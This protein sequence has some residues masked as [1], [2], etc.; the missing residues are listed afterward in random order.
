MY[1]VASNVTSQN[2][3]VQMIQQNKYSQ[4]YFELSSAIV[5]ECGQCLL[6]LYMYLLLGCYCAIFVLIPT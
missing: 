2:S 1:I 5:H 3:F 6:L 4:Y